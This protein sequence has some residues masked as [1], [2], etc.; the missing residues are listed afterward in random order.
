VTVVFG[1]SVAPGAATLG[2]TSQLTLTIQSD[3]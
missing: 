3:R 1:L 2:A